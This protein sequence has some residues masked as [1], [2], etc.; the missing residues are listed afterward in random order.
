MSGVIDSAGQE[1]PAD[2][3]A[4]TLVHRFWLSFIQSITEPH[5]AEAN[6]SDTRRLLEG[7]LAENVDKAVVAALEGRPPHMCG[8]FG[9]AALSVMRSRDK[10]DDEP[11]RAPGGGGFPGRGP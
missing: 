6:G 1:A 11:F 10:L 5:L 3:E 2:G 8:S 9:R 4:E 7:R